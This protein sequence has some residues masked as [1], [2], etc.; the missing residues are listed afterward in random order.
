LAI[1][2]I[3]Q[4]QLHFRQAWIDEDNYWTHITVKKYLQE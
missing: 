1:I 4:S 2:F 3:F